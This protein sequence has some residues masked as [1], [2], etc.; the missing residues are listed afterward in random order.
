LSTVTS[1]MVEVGK[2]GELQ[3]GQMKMV[4]IR[5][6]EILLARVGEKYYAAK[7]RCPH[8][9]GNL[10][11]G[12]LAGTVI[13][14]PRHGSRFDLSDGHVVRWTSWPSA[15]IA[16]DQVRSRKRSIFTYQVTIEGDKI[17]VKL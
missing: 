7:N 2:A 13:T 8:M 1:E 10:S 9:G 4:S 15:L 6:E 16:I 5:G 17:M 11:K 12:T 14:C 3:S